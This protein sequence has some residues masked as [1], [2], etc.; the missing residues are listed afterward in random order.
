MACSPTAGRKGSRPFSSAVEAFRRSLGPGR[1]QP[2]LGV[3]QELAHGPKGHRRRPAGT[4]FDR[5][6][7]GFSAVLG[8]LGVAFVGILP[9]AIRAHAERLITDSPS[10]DLPPWI[11]GEKERTYNA[12]VPDQRPGYICFDRDNVQTALHRGNGV[13]ICDLL[14]PDNALVMVKR[15]KGS[16]ALSHLFSQALVAVQTLRN[17]P[18][19][20]VRFAEKVAAARPR[21]VPVP[22]VGGIGAVQRRSSTTCGPSRPSDDRPPGKAY[23]AYSTYLLVRADAPPGRRPSGPTPRPRA[24]PPR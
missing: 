6:P 9:K 3:A 12:S 23:G 7:L 17:S 19:G 10:V 11:L 16:D 14:S 2:C 21:L 18:E 22:A 24:S 20:R 13:E 5:F 1:P 15:A 4:A 8:P